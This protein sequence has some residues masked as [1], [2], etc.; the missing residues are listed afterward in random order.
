VLKA[1]KTVILSGASGF[2]GKNLIK[3]FDS[4]EWQILI[5]KRPSNYNL[6]PLLPSLIEIDL[7]DKA[8]LRQVLN[9][10]QISAVIHL[11][12]IYDRNESL[13]LKDNIWEVNYCLGEQ[14]L[15]IALHSNAH[16]V[17]IESYLQY[18]VKKGTEYLKSKLAFSEL[19]EQK[20][21][22]NYENITSL[23]LFDNYGFGD[24]RQKILDKLIRAKQFSQVL[25]LEQPSSFILLTFIED[26]TQA[27]FRAISES[28]YGRYRVNSEDKYILGDLAYYIANFPDAKEPPTIKERVYNAE[29]YPLLDTFIQ[30]KRVVDFLK[31]NLSSELEN[32][33]K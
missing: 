13:S 11:A 26:V 28:R 17:H 27:I 15:E 10:S 21:S 8:E 3:C 4:K 19:V 18:E 12:T 23:I 32:G 31:I 9:L 24:V 14:L 16:F 1:K 20:K 2:T 6:K 29:S 33:S 25:Q 5:I 22:L 30:T 7:K